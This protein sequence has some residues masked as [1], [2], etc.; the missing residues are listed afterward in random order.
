MVY[1][2]TNGDTAQMAQMV[3]EMKLL[4]VQLTFKGPTKGK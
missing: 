2:S 4:I 3:L 1:F